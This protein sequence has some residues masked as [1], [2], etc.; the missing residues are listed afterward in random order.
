MSLLKALF[1]I[2]ALWRPAF[3]K[4]EAFIR[5]MELA[6]ACLCTPSQKKITSMAI[7]LGRNISKLP[8]AD[9][10]FYSNRKWNVENLFNPILKL[11]NKHVES[12]YICF[13]ADDTKIHK[14]GKKIPGAGWQ[15]DPLGPKFQKNLIW[16]IRYLQVSV[17]A[18]LYSYYENIPARALPVRFIHAPSIKKPKKNASQENLE[19]YR[20]LLKEHNL[21]TFFVSA[22]KNLRKALDEM[23]LAAKTMIMVGDGSFCNKTC[24]GIDDSRIVMLARCRK[25][26]KLCFRS[27]IPHKVYDDK[28]FTPESIRK[29]QGIPWST[30]KIFY[31]G[32][33][34][35][36]QYKEV[37][38]VLWQNGTKR[39]PL[40][41]IVLAAVPYRNKS[42]KINYRDPA[43]LLSTDLNVP[44]KVLIQG[45]LDRWQI[46]YNHRDE[47]SILGVG[48][49]QV[50]NKN[51]VVKQPAF[52][53]AVYSALLMANIIAYKDQHHPDFGENPRWR[54][55]AKH[56]TTR[57]L[58]GLLRFHLI[59]NTEAL[60][61]LGLARLKLL[62]IASVFRHAA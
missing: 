58:V 21:S 15:I 47:K 11:V 35:E 36:M 9:Y 19:D 8:I 4:E 44:T 57:A 53:V 3:C 14:T 16:G 43:Y 38:N 60:A 18:P 22:A 51:S 62:K 50:R 33:W 32:E 37:S 5:A 31:G 42:G 24:M 49:A 52:H 45:Y 61:Q 7:F 2:L 10:M 59:E 26:S 39:K 55:K 56:N 27:T 54:P 30:K 25:D 41:V 46:E 34:R 12:E 6:L 23:G 13:A 40:R 29:D 28:K 17:I 20:A 1:E 48:H